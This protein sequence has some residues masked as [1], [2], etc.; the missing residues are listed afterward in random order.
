MHWLLCVATKGW[1]LDQRPDCQ[2]LRFVSWRSGIP[3]VNRIPTFRCWKMGR[4]LRWN[5][6]YLS[7]QWSNDEVTP[8]FGQLKLW[9][10]TMPATMGS[11]LLLKDSNGNNHATHWEG[12]SSYSSNGAAFCRHTGIG[13]I[14]VCRQ[15]WEPSNHAPMSRRQI[16]TWGVHSSIGVATPKEDCA[17]EQWRRRRSREVL[18]SHHLWP[19]KANVHHGFSDYIFQSTRVLHHRRDRGISRIGKSGARKCLDLKAWHRQ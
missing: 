10:H 11:N 7:A 19:D 14:P 6:Q 1:S 16:R 9:R 17:K 5:D 3:H 2:R 12:F 4:L 8:I 18:Q 13:R 15:W